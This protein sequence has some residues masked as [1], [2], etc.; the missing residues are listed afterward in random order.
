MK[1]L[2][3]AHHYT[4]NASAVECVLELGDLSLVLLLV[5]SQ[6]LDATSQHVDLG[7]EVAQLSVLL[8]DLLA[9]VIRRFSRLFQSATHKSLVK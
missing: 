4:D 3:A 1:T 6:A 2:I 8:V 5:G 7:L 9:N